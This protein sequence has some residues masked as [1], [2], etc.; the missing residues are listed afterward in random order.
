MQFYLNNIRF[1]LFV[2]LKGKEHSRD[3]CVDLLA[4][5]FVEKNV[6]VFPV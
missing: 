6:I 3:S 4:S 5:N 1:G 2:G